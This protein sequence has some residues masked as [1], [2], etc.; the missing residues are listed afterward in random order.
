MIK[1]GLIEEAKA[2]Y[3]QNINSKVV[4]NTIGYQDI[5]IFQW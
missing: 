1:D 2:L 4:L 5:S 3:N